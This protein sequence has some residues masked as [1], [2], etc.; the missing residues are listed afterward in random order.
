VQKMHSC[1]A[2]AFLTELKTQMLAGI[3]AISV[4]CVLILRY[5]FHEGALGRAL[6]LVRCLGGRRLGRRN[7]QRQV[8]YADYAGCPPASPR[9]LR[10]CVN[11][12]EVRISSTGVL[13]NPHSER[14]GSVAGCSKVRGRQPSGTASLDD[15]RD[16]TLLYCGTSSEEYICVITSGATAGCRLV[17]EAYFGGDRG[18]RLAK[19]DGATGPS[20]RGVDRNDD[21]FAFLVDNHTSV[22]GIQGV[23]GVQ[24]RSV[25]VGD[26]FGGEHNPRQ[27]G[28]RLFAFPGESNLSGVRYSLEAIDHWQARG[29]RVLL[30]AAKSCASQPPDLGLYK[31]D[32][33]VLS[34]YKLFGNPSGLGALLVRRDAAAELD[35]QAC[36]YYGGGT[37][38]YAVPELQQLRRKRLPYRFEHGTP[39][40][41]GA[42]QALVGF[43][44]LEREFGRGEAIDVKAVRVATVLA[45]RLLQLT[46]FNGR[47]VCAVYGSWSDIVSKY[48]CE[49][50]VRTIQGPIVAFNVMDNSGRVVSCRDIERAGELR[51]I[52]LRS[53]SVC[54]SGGL[55]MA[56]GLSIDEIAEVWKEVVSMGDGEDGD[57]SASCDDGMVLP[58]GTP[59]GVLRASFGYASVVE[60]AEYIADF[61]SETFRVDKNHAARLDQTHAD[62][63]VLEISRIY[64]YPIKSC[65]PQRVTSWEVDSTRSLAYDRR[66]KLVDDH[67]AALTVKHCPSLS[68]IAPKIDLERRVLRIE[69]MDDNSPVG[70]LTCAEIP[71]DGSHEA[72]IP[73]SAWLSGKLGVCCMLVR[74]NHPENYSNRSHTLV[75]YAPTI[76]HIR[77]A[78]GSLA[79]FDEFALRMRPNVILKEAGTSTDT[80]DQPVAAEDAWGELSC[81]SDA[82]VHAKVVR[83]CTRCDRVC[84]DPKTGILDKQDSGAVLK[85]IIATKRS[86]ASSFLT[87]GVL[88][89]FSPCLLTET[90]KLSVTQMSTV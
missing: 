50:D 10:A 69:I 61:I 53:G 79:T 35:E 42:P 66:W 73:A 15:L 14:G 41:L 16:K 51:G 71:L 72:A 24:A 7:G 77:S 33:V 1:V 46:H 54:N 65:Q 60:D 75:M 20:G 78:S 21:E 9:L 6:A 43:S 64:I 58:D 29:Y 12:L 85:S 87:L 2:L 30:D 88:V 37:V 45:R 55:R 56:L 23:C 49:E 8:V 57:P 27:R 63:Q 80:I 4:V 68:C 82:A 90:L 67:G 5:I 59:T 31:A 62:N 48:Q 22:V 76:E 36:G 18:R 19:H 38:A 34:Y 28:R 13:R 70:E 86:P 81:M 74:A 11:D 26:L 3:V 17:G 39:S 89:D 83:P 84:I 40:Y 32:F 52:V 44:W 47:P 25:E